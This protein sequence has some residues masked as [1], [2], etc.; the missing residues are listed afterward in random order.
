[1]LLRGWCCC[2]EMWFSYHPI[3][4]TLLC[5]LTPFICGRSLYRWKS[6]EKLRNAKPLSMVLK[7]S[8]RRQKVMWSFPTYSISAL[9]FLFYCLF[10]SNSVAVDISQAH[11]AL[12]KC[13]L[14]DLP[15]WG[16]RGGW[17]IQ[18]RGRSQWEFLL[19]PGL[20]PKLIDISKPKVTGCRIQFW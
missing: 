4:A 18:A 19:C 1:M 16:E 11:S 7:F 3:W 8:S 20:F 9:E 15:E 5:E 6:E 14:A 10:L 12:L 13:P 2:I 17:N